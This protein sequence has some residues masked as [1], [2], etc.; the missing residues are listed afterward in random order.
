MKRK[1][2]LETK[3]DYAEDK[4]SSELVTSNSKV[5]ATMVRALTFETS[6]LQASGEL[7]STLELTE[8]VV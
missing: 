5:Q 6:G 2:I 4:V 3:M 1:H 7:A 8:E